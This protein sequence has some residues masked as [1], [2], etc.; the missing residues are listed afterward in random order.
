MSAYI[1]MV[2]VHPRYQAL[3]VGR[4]LMQALMDGHDGI[5]FALSAADGMGDWY[6]GLGFEPDPRA[7]VRRRRDDRPAR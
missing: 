5:R 6:A 3:G 2:V 7:M 1:S 4:R